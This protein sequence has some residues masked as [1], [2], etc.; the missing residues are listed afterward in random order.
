VSNKSREKR[1]QT[2]TK[3]STR[4]QGELFICRRKRILEKKIGVIQGGAKARV[5]RD[6]RECK[7][8]IGQDILEG[9]GPE[10]SKG[11]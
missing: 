1:G 3:Q 5:E 4:Y 9:S 10:V 6:K 11:I 7:E 2:A 8:T